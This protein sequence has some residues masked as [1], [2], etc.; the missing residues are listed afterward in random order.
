[1]ITGEGRA[2]QGE[3]L[4]RAGALVEAGRLRPLLNERVFSVHEIADAHALVES[5]SLGKV[6]VDL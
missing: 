4:A 3:I 5:G 6:V 1:L 2:H